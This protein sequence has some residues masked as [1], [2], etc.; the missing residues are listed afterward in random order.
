MK[1]GLQIGQNHACFFAVT[2][3]RKDSQILSKS[4]SKVSI[5]NCLCQLSNLYI[6]LM[7]D[8]R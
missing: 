1:F 4:N 5:L 6:P 8:V 2:K 7:L 3:V